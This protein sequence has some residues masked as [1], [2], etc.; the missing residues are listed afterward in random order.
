MASKIA[1]YEYHKRNDPTHARMIGQAF[2][3]AGRDGMSH[4]DALAAAKAQQIA[5]RKKAAKKGKGRDARP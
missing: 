3:L 4:A 5:A 2:K 1:R